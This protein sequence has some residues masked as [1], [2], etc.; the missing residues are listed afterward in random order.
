MS[1]FLQRELTHSKKSALRRRFLLIERRFVPV[2]PGDAC[3]KSKR[4]RLLLLRGAMILASANNGGQRG[5]N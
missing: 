5:S 4:L 1:L 2:A 3:E